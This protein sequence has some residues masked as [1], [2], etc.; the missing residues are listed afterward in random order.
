MLVLWKKNNTTVL[1]SLPLQVRKSYIKKGYGRWEAFDRTGDMVFYLVRTKKSIDTLQKRCSN[2]KSLS[3][4]EIE[5]IEAAAKVVSKSGLTDIN[6]VHTTKIKKQDYSVLRLIERDCPICDN[7]HFVEERRRITQALLK[8]EIVDYEQTYYACPISDDEE[9]E[10]V[11]AGLMDENLLR[12]RN[13][14]R[15][16]K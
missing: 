9:N 1:G 11:P 3:L 15:K 6:C 5:E 4:S 7:V 2:L 16:F 12:A 13:A 10:F 8:D 14:L